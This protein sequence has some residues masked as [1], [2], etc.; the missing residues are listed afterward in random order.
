VISLGA[1]AAQPPTATAEPAQLTVQGSV[2][3]NDRVLAPNLARI[4]NE[5]GVRLNVI[6]NKSIW[7]LIALLEGRSDL[8]MIS[9]DL[10]DEIAVARAAAPTLPYHQLKKFEIARARIA[11]VVHPTNPVG[12]LNLTEIKRALVGEVINW[13]EIGGPDLPIR[14]VATQNGGGTVVSVRA[15]LLDGGNIT[16][17]DAIRLE[18]ARHVLKAVEQEPGAL[19]I[20]QLGLARRT[21]ITILQTDMP[22]EQRLSLV[23]LGEPVAA[24]KAVIEAIMAAA[25]DNVL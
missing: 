19:G 10:D 5:S 4:E 8:A 7:G 16:A 1:L 22:V 23:T 25:A 2:T 24:V 12:K 14:V 21:G 11:F 15:Q 17:K 6:P 13:K 20:A 18:S 9:A 3:F